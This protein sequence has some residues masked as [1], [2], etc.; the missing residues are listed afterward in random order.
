MVLYY[1]RYRSVIGIHTKKISFTIR[2]CFITQHQTGMV[3]FIVVAVSIS[4]FVQV[5]ILIILCANFHWYIQ[6]TAVYGGVNRTTVR[7]QTVVVPLKWLKHTC[8]VLISCITGQKAAYVQ[9]P[10]NMIRL[11]W[12]LNLFYSEKQSI[13]LLS[14]ISIYEFY[15]T[16]LLQSLGYILTSHS[17]ILEILHVL[18]LF[19]K[20]LGSLLWNKT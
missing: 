14:F 7:G 12:V 2:I 20:S 9:K 5:I 19:F 6:Y 15:C 3:V 13:Q 4:L 17:I 8:F 18:S 10:P 1:F 16:C 11:Y